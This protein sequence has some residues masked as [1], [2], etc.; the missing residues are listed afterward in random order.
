MSLSSL[1][2]TYR[3]F[4]PWQSCGVAWSRSKCDQSPFRTTVRTAS[5]GPSGDAR[6]PI[7][8]PMCGALYQVLRNSLPQLLMLV[9]R[10][11]PRIC[12]PGNGTPSSVGCVLGR[13]S[14]S[15]IG[16][17][18]HRY[19]PVTPQHRCYGVLRATVLTPR[20]SVLPAPHH[21][22][23]FQY[24]YPMQPWALKREGRIA[25]KSFRGE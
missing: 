24:F 3:A 7:S 1:T 20:M 17:S 6:Q 12:A 25:D 18:L 2:L 10:I 21:T 16:L 13:A 8:T 14:I 19:N 23:S 22:W 9:W 11:S 15:A 5:W 4:P